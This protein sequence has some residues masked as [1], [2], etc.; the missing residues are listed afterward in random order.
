[1]QKIKGRISSTSQSISGSL[2]GSQSIY[3]G[4]GTRQSQYYYTKQEIDAFREE[5]RQYVDN[6]VTLLDLQIDAA[7]HKL[8]SSL[9]N[10]ILT[11]SLL[12]AND[13]IISTTSV[14]L[15]IDT[16]KY[17]VSGYYDDTTHS[18]IFVYNDGNTISV[19]LINLIDDFVLLNELDSK[20]AELG[21]S[22]VI[23][24]SNPD[25]LIALRSVTIDGTQYKVE[26]RKQIYNNS[27]VDDY[28]HQ[29]DDIWLCETN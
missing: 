7:G 13:I 4:V 21:Y 27:N 15:N 18:L 3:G 17:I 25:A 10:N 22:K 1:M 12:D 9:S 26:G 24:N 6:Q 8:T 28:E 11:T 29:V 5:D 19:S 20:V 16:N 14:E 2:S 23:A